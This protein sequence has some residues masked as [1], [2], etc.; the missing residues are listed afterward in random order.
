MLATSSTVIAVVNADGYQ[1]QSMSPCSHFTLNKSNC[2]GV[3][4]DYV[5]EPANNRPHSLQKAKGRL[6]LAVVYSCD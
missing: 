2:A 3:D 4:I 6:L 5:S 1:Q